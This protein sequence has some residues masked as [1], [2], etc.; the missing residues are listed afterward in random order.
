MAEISTTLP[1]DNT[2]NDE[3]NEILQRRGSSNRVIE[4]ADA[5]SY[6]RTL[7]YPLTYSYSYHPYNYDALQ[8]QD[9][10][11]AAQAIEND[12]KQQQAAQEPTYSDN[13]LNYS[14]TH[15]DVDFEDQNDDETRERMAKLK[16]P[17][18][19]IFLEW[20]NL[21]YTI[22]LP[23]Q[24]KRWRDRIPHRHKEEKTLEQDTANTNVEA[25]ERNKKE[26]QFGVVGD[27]A[28]LESGATTQNSGHNEQNDAMENREG[29]GHSEINHSPAAERENNPEVN[30][31]S[32]TKE[33][34]KLREKLSRSA[35]AP[36][37]TLLT[38]VNGTVS[39][40]EFLAIMGP[41]GSGKTTILSVLSNRVRKGVTGELL[42]NGEPPTRDY[43]R[44]VAYVLQDDVL[45]A[46]LTVEQTLTYTA[47]LRLPNEIPAAEKKKAV[48]E[49]IDVLNLNKARNTIIGG[50]F[51][52][53]I[54][55]GERKRVNIGN[56]LLANPSLILL[57][58]PTSGLDTS[59]ALNLLKVLK[60]MAD[61]GY[62]VVS[63]I[64]QPSSQMF[65]LFDKLMILVDGQ[66]IYF[67][68]ASGAV[69]YFSS[70][71]LNCAQ[72]Y[73]PAD[74]MMGLILQ[75]ELRK[76]RGIKNQLI[77]AWSERAENA[78]NDRFQFE[79][80]NEVRYLRK[81]DR[82][83]GNVKLEMTAPIESEKEKKKSS[84]P[85]PWFKQFSIL[86]QRSFRQT[87][88]VYFSKLPFI[89]IIAIAVIAGIFWLQVPKRES[90][91][92]D[93][94]GAL[95]FVGIFA[96]G[97]FPLFNSLYNFPP[98]RAVIQRERAEGAYPLSAYFIAKMCSEIFFELLFP[99]I[100]VAIAY[101]MI[102]LRGGFTRW[103]LFFTIVGLLALA[104]S[105]LGFAISAV[106]F[107]IK[108]AGVLASIIQLTA[109]LMGGFYV[110]IS[111]MPDWIS[112]IHYISWIKY[113]Y[114]AM[115]I[116]EFSGTLYEQEDDIF[117]EFD[118]PGEPGGPFITGD[119]ILDTQ[120]IIVRSIVANIFILAGFA[121]FFRTLAF[122]LL[123][124]SLKP[125]Q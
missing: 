28:D 37:R 12:L 72:F 98:E 49:V 74:F 78:L 123:K 26:T 59:T 39:P 66:T 100:F 122:L 61:A 23:K 57:D 21:S 69:A 10:N 64:H 43:K 117:T 99:L 80:G 60:G 53:G 48:N 67:G 97:F 38:N 88:G 124:W 17:D 2:A 40:G 110:S 93:E 16:G 106:I 24:R 75:E 15:I 85:I 19:P 30:D 101:P 112:W 4:E 29:N 94:M 111:N 18:I 62:T 71:G 96:G 54:S 115:M 36:K 82:K 120:D 7:E 118:I 81:V 116:N 13:Q 92:G 35:R 1:Y 68:P 107:D 32:K 51:Q 87:R 9:L 52:R 5:N 3:R 6:Y 20:K 113:A 8:M 55:G 11:S 45:F 119:Q 95:F 33:K 14:I 42:V 121:I 27:Q 50:P 102:G 22:T 65:E 70:L 47:Q 114:D 25:E 84:Y 109:M 31:E 56:A 108:M 83:S 58:E 86:W 76:G 73:N 105:G 34:K 89:Q 125:R 103:L 91:I 77:A 41:T 90:R 44:R 79:D 63:S 46:N 104:T